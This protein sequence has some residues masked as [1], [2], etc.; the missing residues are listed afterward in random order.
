MLGPFLFCEPLWLTLE[1]AGAV[2]AQTLN[3]H[4]M[5]IKGGARL[6][7]CAESQADF[8]FPDTAPTYKNCEMLSPGSVLT[9]EMPSHIISV[10]LV[11]D[12]LACSANSSFQVQE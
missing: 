2:S 12:L 11:L 1:P 9:L 6:S 4:P 7:V 3:L 5:G 8:Q 10:Y